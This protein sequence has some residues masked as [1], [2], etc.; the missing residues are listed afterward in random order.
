MTLR[1]TDLK[2]S[3]NV[4]KEMLKNRLNTWTVCDENT[5]HK[6]GLLGS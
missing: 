1:G 4:E 5:R 6:M 3:A 2:S